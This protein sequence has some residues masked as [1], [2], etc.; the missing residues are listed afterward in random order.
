[1]G[2]E[3]NVLEMVYNYYSFH[4]TETARRDKER[5]ATSHLIMQL[6]IFLTEYVS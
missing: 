5:A 4:A 1:M 2:F 6:N 3:D